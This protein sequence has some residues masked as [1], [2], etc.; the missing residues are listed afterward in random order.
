MRAGD[1]NRK[2]AIQ[3]RGGGADEWGTPL[4]DV[5]VDVCK[6][7]ASIRHLSGTET[8]KA[9]AATST[10]RASIRIR[11]RSGIDA[12]MRV[13]HGETVYAIKAVM[14]EEARR[15]YVDLVAEVVT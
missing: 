2:I 5:W 8:I 10:V 6:P 11:Y 9:D 1:L 14:P 3:K 4:P 13:L 7:W 15:E 12:S